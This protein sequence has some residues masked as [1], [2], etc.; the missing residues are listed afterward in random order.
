VPP[1]EDT[2]AIVEEQAPVEE[3]EEELLEAP[4]QDGE[5]VAQISEPAGA[6]PLE[7]GEVG[8]RRRRRRRRRGGD[9]PFGEN[10]PQDAPQPRDD[11]LAVVAEIGGDLELPSSPPDTFDRR[12]PRGEEERVR[13]SRRSRGARNRFSPRA[14]DENV[15][16]AIATSETET[17]PAELAAGSEADFPQMSPQSAEADSAL[18]K[19]IAPA[20][21][22]AELPVTSEAASSPPNSAPNPDATAGPPEPEAPPQ[23]SAEPAPTVDG[24]ARPRRSGWWQRARASV[25]GD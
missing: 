22:A 15:S 12:G 13:R 8:R 4:S 23:P 14:E 18:D 16:E 9:R 3:D 24:P 2:T 6:L 5:E 10:P 7:D 1:A 11:G 19:T 20:S 21:S 17:A 25:M